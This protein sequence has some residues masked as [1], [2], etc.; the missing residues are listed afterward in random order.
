VQVLTDQDAIALVVFRAAK[1]AMIHATTNP[2]T[3]MKMKP[4]TII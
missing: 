2:L 4:T 1:I 3:R